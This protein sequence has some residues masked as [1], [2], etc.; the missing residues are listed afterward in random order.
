[1]TCRSLLPVLLLS[2]ALACGKDGD[3]TDGSTGST[4]S[5]GGMTGGSTEGVSSTGGTPTTGGTT[6]AVTTGDATDGTGGQTGGQTTGQSSTTGI[7]VSGFERF[8]LNHSAGPCPPGADCDGFIEV[9]ASG[10]LRVETF[11]EVG[12]PV[13]EVELS[14]EDL[15]AALPVF[16][17]PALRAL[18]DGPDPACEPPS[19]IFESMVVV[20][21]GM[22]H[23]GGTTFCDQP[24][25]A[26]ARDMASALSEKYVP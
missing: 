13:K 11:G 1:M 12:N 26:A 5:T 9:L 19:D 7:D 24:P 20:V 14:P 3:S 22:S 16:A 21:D 4:G 10:L 6:G 17:D 25:I 15:A 8:T 2:V 18:L 23:D